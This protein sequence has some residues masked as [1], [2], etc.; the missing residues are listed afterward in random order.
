[1]AVQTK[2]SLAII[3]ALVLL[4]VGG[5]IY[6][7]IAKLDEHSLGQRVDEK[8]LQLSVEPVRQTE[9]NSCGEAAILM[10]YNHSHADA[11]LDE[12][13]IIRYAKSMGYYTENRFPFT[14]P[15]NMVMIAR[16]FAPEIST[17]I[18]L[19]SDQGLALLDKRLQEEQPVIID[20]LTRLYDP[21]AGAHFVVVTGISV[22]PDRGNAIMIHFND[23]LTGA[24]R[25]A[26]WAGN[27]GIWN[28]WQN[29]KDPGGSGWWMVIPPAD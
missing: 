1:M 11:P 19:T 28:A 10:A 23:P 12:A 2:I 24:E 16:H 6:S 13:R 25:I 26:R 5:P 29:N 3:A 21:R 7:G 27:E 8:P 18:V 17:G 9:L 14:S 4:A 15:A 22:D 20:I